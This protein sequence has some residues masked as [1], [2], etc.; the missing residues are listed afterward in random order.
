MALYI[1]RYHETSL[2]GYEPDSATGENIDLPPDPKNPVEADY[3][4]EYGN[5]KMSFARLGNMQ[6]ILDFSRSQGTSVLVVEMPVHPTFY[7]YVGGETVHQ[8]FQQTI[9]ALVTSHRGSFIPAETCSDIP[10]SGRSNRWHLNYLGAPIF[11]KC[12]AGQLAVLA[13]QQK[14]N[15][16]NGGNLK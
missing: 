2:S 6:S 16:I 4:K 7:V 14:T 3:F 1:K 8:Q 9:T 10:L 12:L 11:S 15:F 5:Y 13:N